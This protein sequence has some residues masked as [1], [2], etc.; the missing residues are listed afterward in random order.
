MDINSY[1]TAMNKVKADEE[2]IN[3]ILYAAKHQ[4]KRVRPRG[5][6]R[7][8]L[9]VIAAAVLLLTGFTVYAA[10]NGIFSIIFGGEKDFS[11]FENLTGELEVHSLETYIDGLK[12]TPVGCATDSY[13]VYSVFRLDFPQALPKSEEYFEHIEDGYGHCTTKLVELFKKFSESSQPSGGCMGKYVKGDEDTLYYVYT[14]SCGDKMS[15]DITL[16]MTCL[17]LA[18][19][20]KGLI[21]D[22]IIYKD[23]LFSASFTVN[24]PE[25]EGTQLVTKGTDMEGFNAKVYPCSIVIDTYDSARVNEVYRTGYLS[26][27]KEAYVTLKNGEKIG[28]TGISMSYSLNRNKTTVNYNSTSAGPPIYDYLNYRGYL[29]FPADPEQ[30]ASLTIGGCTMYPEE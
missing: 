8:T 9:P 6:L 16:D 30:I 18:D 28:V 19:D 21:K 5:R 4:T 12:V 10:S 23:P 7:R 17:S 27:Y 1:K 25:V 24:I 11:P 20:S 14:V 13:T 26:S 22:S 15:G 3:N 2:C 29:S